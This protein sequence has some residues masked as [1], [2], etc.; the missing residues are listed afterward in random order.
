MLPEAGFVDLRIGVTRGI[1]EVADI[2][3]FSRGFVCG[4]PATDQI[5]AR[6]GD[7]EAVRAA[8]EAEYRREFGSNPSRMPLQIIVPEAHRP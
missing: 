5:R 8:M 1:K 6:G 2:A 4:N 7:P 3:P